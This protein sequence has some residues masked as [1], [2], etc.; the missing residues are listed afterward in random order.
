MEEGCLAGCSSLENSFC[1]KACIYQQDYYATKAN[2]G[3][4]PDWWSKQTP[5]NMLNMLPAAH[6]V[7]VK[8][9][10]HKFSWEFTQ[11]RWI[12]ISSFHSEAALNINTWCVC[13]RISKNSK[14]RQGKFICMAQGTH[15]HT[16]GKIQALCRGTQHLKLPREHR[17]HNYCIKRQTVYKREKLRMHK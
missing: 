15:T 8:M 13:N 6:T 4:P 9:I 12:P 2:W 10:R 17:E 5:F 7:N 1:Q 16:K 11:R 14:A 3:T